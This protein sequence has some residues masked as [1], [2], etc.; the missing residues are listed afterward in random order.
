MPRRDTR[1]EAAG[2]EFLA[3]GHLLVEGIPAYKAYTNFPGY[4]LIATNPEV[5]LSCRVQVKSRYET[6][7]TGFPIKNFDCE[8]V[9]LA[10]LNRGKRGKGEDG[11]SDPVFY[12]LPVEVARTANRPSGNW[13]KSYLRHMDQPDQYRDAWNLIREHLAG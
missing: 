13:S 8:F 7:A 6:G 9:V 2:A 4:D 5:G 1:L 10:L 3:L 12:V 11:R